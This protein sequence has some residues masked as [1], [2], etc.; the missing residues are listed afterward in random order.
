MRLFLRWIKCT[1]PPILCHDGLFHFCWIGQAAPA[2]KQLCDVACLKF[3]GRWDRADGWSRKATE[4]QFIT[5]A[6]V[7][8]IEVKQAWVAHICAC[9]QI[10]EREA[11]LVTVGEQY[12][13]HLFYKAI[14][15]DHLVLVEPHDGAA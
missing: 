8:H 12:R 13:I 6:R 9:S 7:D 10:E 3:P 1:D 15:I 2:R 14:V 4:N 5:Q 11:R